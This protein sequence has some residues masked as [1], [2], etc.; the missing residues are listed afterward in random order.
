MST[1]IVI[2]SQGETDELYEEWKN[3]DVKWI[4]N[5]INEIPL[6]PCSLH[7]LVGP[8]QIGKTTLL[9]ILI[10]EKLLKK[11]DPRSIFYYSCDE[12]TDFEEL[13][14][15]LNTYI[16]ARKKWGL[17]NSIIILDEITFVDEWYRAIKSRIDKGFFKRDVLIVTGSS[18]LEILKGKEMFPGR[19]GNGRDII[20]YPMS[21][22]EFVEKFGSISLR[23][24]PLKE[25]M[26]V[27]RAMIANK[28]FYSTIDDV[29]RKYLITGGFP[30]A[31][32]DLFSAGKVSLKTIKTCLDWLIGDWKKFG[33][34]EK[35][36]KEVISFIIRARLSPISWLSIAKEISY[37][38][39]TQFRAILKF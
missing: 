7:F 21:F 24:I 22:S 34:S 25:I 18:S 20:F 15:I 38:H 36:M 13:G 37:L 2:A 10:H 23:K 19:R 12:I 4:P 11:L 33:K 14:D 27:N 6:E 31:I 1:K 17:K 32:I 30:L 9:K 3:K 29:F 28:I 26:D 5:L 8:R 39:L 16:S 35:F